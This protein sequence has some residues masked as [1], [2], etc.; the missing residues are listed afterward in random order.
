MH[1]A[2]DISTFSYNL[3]KK[4]KCSFCSSGHSIT[5]SLNHWIFIGFSILLNFCFLITSDLQWIEV[6]VVCSQT[7]WALLCIADGNREVQHA[8]RVADEDMW[9]DEETLRCHTGNPW[10]II[11][12]SLLYSSKD[13]SLRRPHPAS[14]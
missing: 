7:P 5:T 4:Q 14:V 13:G 12:I 3:S 10:V 8:T 9:G 1:C 2:V 11:S 6:C